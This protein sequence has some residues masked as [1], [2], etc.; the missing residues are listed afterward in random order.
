MQKRVCITC[1]V[2]YSVIAP[3]GIYLC[4]DIFDNIQY[5]DRILSYTIIRGALFNS[6]Y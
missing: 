1:V 6:K 5:V 2:T 4:R 3:E